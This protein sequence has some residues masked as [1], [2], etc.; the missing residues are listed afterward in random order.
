MQYRKLFISSEK[1][2]RKGD[3]VDLETEV[4]NL[5]RN[6]PDKDFTIYEIYEEIYGV[7]PNPDNLMEF[8]YK[9]NP[10]VGTALSSLLE[11][12]EIII[13]HKTSETNINGVYAAG[14]VADKPFKQAITGVAEGC[15]AAYSAFEYLKEKR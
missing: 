8:H 9:V 12:G 14:D 10:T 4:L 7:K 13:D 15:T 11:K 1:N 3:I 5:L 6:N 2:I